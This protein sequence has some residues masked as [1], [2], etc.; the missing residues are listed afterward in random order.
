MYLT[1]MI[2]FKISNTHA[3]ANMSALEVELSSFTFAT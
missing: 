3:S 1:E 2:K